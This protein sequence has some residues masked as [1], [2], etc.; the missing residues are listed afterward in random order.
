MR[1]DLDD[2]YQLCINLW[3]LYINMWKEDAHVGKMCTTII[4][5]VS[6][7]TKLMYAKLSV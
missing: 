7:I 4:Y 6:I 1:R 2:I 5:Q 3:F